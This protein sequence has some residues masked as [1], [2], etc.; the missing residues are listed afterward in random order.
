MKPSLLKDR[1]KAVDPDTK[2]TLLFKNLHEASAWIATH[3]SWDLKRHEAIVWCF[4]LEKTIT[5]EGW[6]RVEG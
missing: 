6:V 1:F 3:P 5:Q 2:E 4:P